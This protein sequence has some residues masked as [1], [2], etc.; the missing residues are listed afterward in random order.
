[1]IERQVKKKQAVHAYVVK[2]K[3][4]A[5]DADLGEIRSTR[6]TIFRGALESD[7]ADRS[8]DRSI[9][10]PTNRLLRA[11]RSQ[12]DRIHDLIDKDDKRA[13]NDISLR[14]QLRAGTPTKTYIGDEARALRMKD[15]LPI[16]ERWL[17]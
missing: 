16:S 14:K 2:F 12:T 6:D 15:A 11:D 5:R 13:A 3:V 10:R 1:M 7:G 4:K 17:C 8:I 9:D